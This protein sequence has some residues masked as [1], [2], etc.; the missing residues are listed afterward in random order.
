MSIIVHLVVRDEL[1]KFPVGYINFMKLRMTG[2]EHHFFLSNSDS[3]HTINEPLNL[4]DNQNVYYYDDLLSE[5]MKPESMNLLRKCDKIIANQPFAMDNKTILFLIR[6]GLSAKT[7][8][9]FWNSYDFPGKGLMHKVKRFLRMFRHP[10][11][12]L[13]HM[14]MRLFVKK[15]AGII[16]LI[17]GDVDALMQTFP[18]AVKSFVA[19]MPGNPLITYDFSARDRH[20]EKNT[21][22]IVVGHSA[23][24]CSHLEGFKLLEH[25]KGENIEIV[26]P[27]S[28][29]LP[30]VRENVLEIGSS[31]FGDKFVPVT[32]FMTKQEYINLL[33][34]CDVGVFP[35]H[36]QHGM[37][38]ISLLLK[39]GKKVYMRDD[40]TM[41]Q[42]YRQKMKYTV[43]P[44]SE[45]EGI[46]LEQLVN[47][48]EELAYN[49]IHIAE[50]YSARSQIPEQWRKVFDD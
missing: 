40:T 38:N 9:Y 14:C 1:D 41:W 19:P 10:R 11:A 4:C 43:Y 25:L 21:Y 12:A 36:A 45:L 22:R 42:Q 39:L 49:N 3:T 34:S 26:C 5:L 7:Y 35:T 13:Q 48:P 6:S 2:Y 30:K 24:E 50:E 16:G 17:D 27:L 20:T 46:T 47:F 28:Y 23:H 37:G 33:G 15:S 31:M 18:E 29:G 44:V 32:D 8:P